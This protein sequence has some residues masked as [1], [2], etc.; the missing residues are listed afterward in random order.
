MRLQDKVIVVP[1]AA[2]GMGLAMAHLFTQ[3]G[4]KVIAADWN[5]ERLNAAVTELQ[6]NGAQ[7]VGVQGD[8]ADQ[9]SAEGLIERAVS[10]FGRLDVLGFSTRQLRFHV[11]QNARIPQIGTFIP[12]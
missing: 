4:A 6:W 2:S 8:I 9:P 12:I 10:E 3:E 11:V 7:A 5:A 1:G